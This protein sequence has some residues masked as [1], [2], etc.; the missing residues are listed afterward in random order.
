M[1]NCMYDRVAETLMQIN[2]RAV[3][4]V[5]TK[6]HHV[7]A[8]I[9]DSTDGKGEGERYPPLKNEVLKVMGRSYIIDWQH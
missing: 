3:E 9:G 7:Q 8:V 2:E 5:G 6:S 4:F 1:V